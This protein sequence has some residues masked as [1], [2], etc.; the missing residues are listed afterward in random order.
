MFIMRCIMY[1]LCTLPMYHLST[2]DRNL[3]TFAQSTQC[4][5]IRSYFMSRM[6]FF[7]Y[8]CMCRIF[9]RK[10]W[11]IDTYY[12]IGSMCVYLSKCECYDFITLFFFQREINKS[13]C[14]KRLSALW[15]IK[16]ILCHTI[17]A[18]WIAIVFKLRDVWN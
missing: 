17:H 4:L 3:Y 2:H 16:M 13:P 8:M 18:A 7:L 1:V 10:Q 9:A 11:K 15:R 12:Q 5:Y 14:R 6:I